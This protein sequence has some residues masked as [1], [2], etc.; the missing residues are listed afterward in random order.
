M[1]FNQ[2][3]WSFGVKKN[4]QKKTHK[5]TKYM[6]KESC[7]FGLQNKKQNNNKNT[8]KKPQKQKQRPPKIPK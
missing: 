5:N 1:K 8:E 2:K 7:S 6:Q 3:S 4:A